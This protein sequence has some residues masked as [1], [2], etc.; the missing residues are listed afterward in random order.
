MALL[1]EERTG[2]GVSTMAAGGVGSEEELG[3]GGPEQRIV[4]DQLAA[5]VVCH[6]NIQSGEG[7]K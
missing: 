6:P 3:Q 4:E 2:H 1:E 7:Q 5:G